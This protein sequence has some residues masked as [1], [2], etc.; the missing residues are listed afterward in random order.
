MNRINRQFWGE[1]GN[2]QT[3]GFARPKVALG[4]DPLHTCATGR[5]SYGR[6]RGGEVGCWLWGITRVGWCACSCA[7]YCPDVVLPVGGMRHG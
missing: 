1:H 5:T 7:G 4:V 2:V 6:P 3:A